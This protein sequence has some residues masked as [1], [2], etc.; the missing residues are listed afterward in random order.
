MKRFYLLLFLLLA[1]ATLSAQNKSVEREEGEDYVKI[2]KIIPKWDA[3]HDIRFSV[4]SYSLVASL[5][6]DGVQ[7]DDLYLGDLHS[8]VYSA[9]T[10]TT[11]QRFWGVYTFSYAYQFRRWFAFGGMVSYGLVTQ[12]RHDLESG[13]VVKR[14]DGHAVSVMPTCRFTYLNREKVQLYSAVSTGMIVGTGA[15][16][17]WMDLTLFGCSVGKN[18]FGFAEVGLGFSGWGR[19]G[20]G[21]RFDAKKK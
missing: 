12:S 10:Y 4:G 21:Y 15:A 11:P 17:P 7:Y 9:T 5:F 8:S 18:L 16:L 13:A 1:A 14:M 2:T 20:I 3:K 6:L 19:V